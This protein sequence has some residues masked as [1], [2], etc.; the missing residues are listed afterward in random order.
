[1]INVCKHDNISHTENYTVTCIIIEQSVNQDCQR[2]H[3]RLLL[4]SVIHV[5]SNKQ[6]GNIPFNL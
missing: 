5:K 2:G 4:K 3:A 1:M 6:V